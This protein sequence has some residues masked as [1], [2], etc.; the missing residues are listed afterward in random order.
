MGMR[1]H[2]PPAR[3]ACECCRLG[4]SFLAP[5]PDVGAGKE[6][7]SSDN[8]W[9]ETPVQAAHPLPSLGLLQTDI[10]NAARIEVDVM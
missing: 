8:S 1:M 4:V 10:A 2:V 7:A 5:I 9:H 3:R 6:H